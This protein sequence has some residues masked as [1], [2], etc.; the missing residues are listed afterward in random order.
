MAITPIFDT[1]DVYLPNNSCITAG[2]PC[3]STWR[4]ISSGNNSCL[5]V[6][7][8]HWYWKLIELLHGHHNMKLLIHHCS[9]CEAGGARLNWVARLLWIC[10]YGLFSLIFLS[11]RIW[12][13]RLPCAWIL[14]CAHFRGPA[15]GG[16][17]Q[18]LRVDPLRGGGAPHGLRVWHEKNPACLGDIFFVGS[19]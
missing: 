10:S 17:P 13:W 8:V 6:R 14:F 16:T 3:Q 9:C 12:W 2:Q 1:L 11:S 4:E 7:T 15:E 18:E 19:P 5:A